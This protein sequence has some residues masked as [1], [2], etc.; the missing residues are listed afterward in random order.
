MGHNGDARDRVGPVDGTSRAWQADGV[1]EA[2]AASGQRGES[3]R[4]HQEWGMFAAGR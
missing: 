4:C 3:Y 1:A 2:A